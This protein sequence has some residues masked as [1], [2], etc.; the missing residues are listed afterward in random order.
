MLPVSGSAFRSL[1]HVAWVTWKRKVLILHRYIV[2]NT[3]DIYFFKDLT[4]Q[5]LYIFS[6]ELPEV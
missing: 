3:N 2:T 1:L 4:W 6:A 5:S